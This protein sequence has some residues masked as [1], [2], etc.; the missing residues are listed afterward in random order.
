MEVNEPSCFCNNFV[1]REVAISSQFHD[2]RQ[3]RF[4]SCL[5]ILH[6]RT[7]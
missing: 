5:V 3:Q 1:R 7:R 2:S 6:R 4:D